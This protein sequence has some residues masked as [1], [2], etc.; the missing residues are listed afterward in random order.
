MSRPQSFIGSKVPDLELKAQ[1]WKLADGLRTSAADADPPGIALDG[2]R[3]C[4]YGAGEDSEISA[5]SR[6]AHRAVADDFGSC[7]PRCF[8]KE[9]AWSIFGEVTPEC[10]VAVQRWFV[11]INGR[12]G[13][14]FD[15]EGAVFRRILRPRR[16]G[17][18]GVE[19]VTVED[20]FGSRGLLLLGGIEDAFREACLPEA[21]A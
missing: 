18:L 20:D 16:S 10:F 12:R 8:G 11:E 15:R 17:G 14:Q 4:E 3:T 6:I 5:P 19:E 2:G 13:R 9:L 1:G 21:R 7:L